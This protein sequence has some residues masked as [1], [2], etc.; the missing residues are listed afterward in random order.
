[1]K[2][3]LARAIEHFTE[4][5]PNEVSLAMVAGGD[6]NDAYRVNYEG[7]VLF[8]KSNSAS[9]YRGMFA[10]EA[11]GLEL[12]S[13]SPLLVPEVIGV[14]QENDTSVLLLEW[15][16][17]GT[18]TD[19]FWFEF[20]AKLAQ[21]HRMTNAHFGLNEYN[22]MARFK[23]SNTLT[24]SWDEFFFSQRIEPQLK[25]AM[26]QN[27]LSPEDLKRAESICQK[28]NEFFVQ[29]APSLL[30]GDLW[31]GNFICNANS[32]AVLVDPAVYYGHR[33]MDLGMTRLFGGFHDLFYEG[34]ESVYVLPYQ[35][36]ASADIA[37][38]YPLLVHVN[39]FGGG[40]IEQ[41]R[42]ILKAFD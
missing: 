5:S 16:N 19:Q 26:T 33:L 4:D 13:E 14:Y 40:Y 39:L 32:E 9:R 23:Q 1:M 34:Y 11:K 6:I 28:A 3:I 30:H 35:W 29:E 10:A 20:G 15:I 27:L 2:Y 21:M 36:K 38:L 24:D 42:T 7:R 22:Y 8:A 37:N 18:R 17:S 31:K 12:L 25:M 41:V